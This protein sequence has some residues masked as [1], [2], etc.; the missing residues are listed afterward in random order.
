M[1]IQIIGYSGS[2]KSTLGKKLSEHYNIP[3]LHLD[4]THYYGDWQER[5]KEEQEAIIN[6]FIDENE[7]WIV[8]GNYRKVA[9]RR[10]EECDLL[11]FLN[12]NRFYCYK[13]ARE[14]YKEWKGKVRDSCPC[15][16]K[17]NW[18]FQSYILFGSR[19]RKKKKELQ[20]LI[21]LAKGEKITF[22][23]RKQLEKYLNEKGIK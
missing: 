21:D 5:T 15:E 23:N 2:G 11:I 13:K 18:D 1:K 8:D 6:K 12:Y 9:K 22:K 20:S 3:V 10:F 4:N 7:S 17:F 19:T 16:E 14:R